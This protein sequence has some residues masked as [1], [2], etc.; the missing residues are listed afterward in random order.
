[1]SGCRAADNIAAVKIKRAGRN[2]S[3]HITNP[4]WQI[5]LKRAARELVSRLGLAEFEAE[6]GQVTAM[7]KLVLV[8]FGDK[9]QKDGTEARPAVL[10]AA[11][12]CGCSTKSVQRV[13]ARWTALG[14]MTIYKYADW[15]R[16]QPNYYRFNMVLIQELV[17]LQNEGPGDTVSPGAIEAPETD[18]PLCPPAGRQDDARPSDTES[19]NPSYTHPIPTHPPKSEKPKR[20]DPAATSD[21]D[22]R[23][24]A[25]S[26]VAIPAQKKA[27]ATWNKAKKGMQ[28][29]LDEGTYRSWLA[30]LEPISDDGETLVLRHPKYQHVAEQLMHSKIKE[31]NAMR[32]FTHRQIKILGPHE[33]FEWEE[34]KGDCSSAA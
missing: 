32:G 27:S 33:R 1:M 16:H 11:Q 7:D 30:P 15:A 13:L 17:S 14:L 25:S 22:K 20:T 6:Y 23:S 10:T 12:A 9:A 18:A 28:E 8:Y 5:D 24:S 26:S 34:P 31:M 4:L 3:V 21:A 29:Y 2:M 19:P